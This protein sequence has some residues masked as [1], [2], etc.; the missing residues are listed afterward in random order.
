MAS[1]N[2]AKHLAILRAFVLRARRIAEHSL[3]QDEDA[4]RKLQHPSF[5]VTA[6]AETRETGEFELTTVL[7]PEEQV[8]S[9]AARV[10]PLLLNEESVYHAKVVGAL[11][12]F[13]AAA[14]ANDDVIALLRDLKKRWAAIKPKGMRRAHYDVLVQGASGAPTERLNDAA[15]AFAWIYGDVVHADS[16]RRDASRAF[17]VAERYRAAVPMVAQL[18]VLT[19]ETLNIIRDVRSKGALLELDEVFGEDVTVKDS[20]F[21]DVAKVYAAEYDADG[22]LP[23]PP[24]MDEEF[25]DAWRPFLETMGDPPAAP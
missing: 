18:M 6:T 9:A 15:L 17:G 11:L 12:Y 4:L 10:R 23:D 14:K 24:A 19:I 2:D 7:P 22:N 20:T 1:P 25:G 13:A 5:T 16:E 3:A 21:R 8:E